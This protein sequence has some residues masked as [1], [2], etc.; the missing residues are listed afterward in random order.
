MIVA[1]KTLNSPFSA[2]DRQNLE[3]RRAAE[4]RPAAGEAAG[5]PAQSPS[6]GLLLRRHD[7]PQHPDGHETARRGGR[8]PAHR[9]VSGGF[10]WRVRERTCVSS[11]AKWCSIS[12]MTPHQGLYVFLTLKHIIP[13][14]SLLFSLV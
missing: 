14:L 1:V 7:R 3:Q 6:G 8:V 2:P 11:D 9:Q 4:L 10:T 13:F 5:S 12:E